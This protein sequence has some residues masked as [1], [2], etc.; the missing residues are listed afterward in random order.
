MDD[1]AYSMCT[2][3]GFIGEYRFSNG[4]SK[5]TYVVECDGHCY[6]ARHSTVAD[7]LVNAAI[8]R[9]VAKSPPPRVIRRAETDGRAANGRLTP[10]TW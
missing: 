1:N 7:A 3:V 4:N 10:A 8:K 9:H 2:V 6:P 5:Y